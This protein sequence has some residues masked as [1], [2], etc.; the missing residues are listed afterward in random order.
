[1]NSMKGLSRRIGVSIV[2][3]FGW[4]SF[5]LRWIGFYWSRFSPGQNNIILIVSFLIFIAIN[6]V[7]WTGWAFTPHKENPWDDK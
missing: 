6:G 1:M 5:V 2:T 3:F 4:V 7:M